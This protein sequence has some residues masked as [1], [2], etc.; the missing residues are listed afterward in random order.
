MIKVH[1][2]LNKLL[3][4]NGQRSP[5]DRNHMIILWCFEKLMQKLHPYQS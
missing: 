4:L 3:M 5:G 1:H 2:Q